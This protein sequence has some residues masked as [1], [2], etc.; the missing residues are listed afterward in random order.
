MNSATL[1]RAALL[2]VVAASLGTWVVKSLRDTPAATTTSAVSPSLIADGVAVINFHGTLRCPTC[3]GI[4]ALSQKVID[5][6]FVAEKEEGRIAWSSIDF[7]KPENAHFKDD[8]DLA[9]SNVVVVR[10]E[11]GVDVGWK[12]LDDVWTHYGE[13]PVFRSYV[14]AAVAEALAQH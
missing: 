9:S 6:E 8:Y 4:G 12:R 1:V 13:E 10:R 2:L 11:H 5:E 14:H 3:V 7:D